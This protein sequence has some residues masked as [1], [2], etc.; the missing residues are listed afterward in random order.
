[1]SDT[2]RQLNNPLLDA[3]SELKATGRPNL[4]KV[5]VGYVPR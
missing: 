1:M 2:E 5:H 3:V 4:N